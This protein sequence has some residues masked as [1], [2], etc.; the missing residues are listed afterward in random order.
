MTHTRTNDTAR[1]VTRT[2]KDVTTM[3]ETIMTNLSLDTCAI[4]YAY[5]VAHDAARMNVD[6]ADARAMTRLVR[7]VSIA[8]DIRTIN[9]DNDARALMTRV[10]TALDIAR[11]TRNVR[12]AI[13]LDD[14][15]DVATF[16]AYLTRHD[17][18]PKQCARYVRRIAR[19]AR[20][21]LADDLLID[22]NERRAINNR[23]NVRN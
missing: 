15:R 18:A 19:Y 16:V 4:T 22:R 6:P 21:I 8:R 5:V 9:A 1:R 10:N 3:R 20:A 13:D 14:A 12:P 23:R 11:D 2:T 7:D 17:D